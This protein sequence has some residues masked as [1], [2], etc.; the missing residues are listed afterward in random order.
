VYG[1]LSVAACWALENLLVAII[2]I[3]RVMRWMLLDRL[4]PR[5]DFA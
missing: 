1:L 3:V 4:D 5:L 2:C